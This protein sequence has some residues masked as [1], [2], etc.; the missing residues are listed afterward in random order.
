MDMH[1]LGDPV[2]LSFLGSILK[3][4]VILLLIVGFIPGLIVGWL[5]GKST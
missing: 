3:G 4:A 1:V 5:V 2:F